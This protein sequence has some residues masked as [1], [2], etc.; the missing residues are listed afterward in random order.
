MT[1]PESALGFYQALFAP[2]PPDHDW[3]R[4]V[5]A[6]LDLE[7]SIKLAAGLP[8]AYR[9]AQQMP[10][11]DLKQMAMD[12]EE[13]AHSDKPFFFA[14]LRLGVVNGREQ[15]DT[16][17]QSLA[18]GAGLLQHGGR[19]MNCLTEHDYAEHLPAAVTRDLFAQGL[20]YR[21]GFLVNS[22]EL[23]SLVHLP[24]S[25]IIDPRRQA[26]A[27]LETLPPE[28]SLSRGTP[29]GQCLYAGMWRSVCIPS[30]MRSKHVHLIGRPGMGKS[31][32]IE[33]MVLHDVG[34]GEGVAVL[35]PHGQMVQRLLGLLP[36]SC[37]DRVIYVDF[38]D[39]EWVPIWNP[40]I[41][42]PGTP[43]GRV[44]E[45]LVGAFK[46]FVTGWGDRLEHMLRHAIFGLMHLPQASL[47]DV[48]NLLRCQSAESERLRPLVIEAMDN[49]LAKA[50]WQEDF[51]KYRSADITPAQHKLGKLVTTAGSV[52]LML[53]QSDSAFN[54][55]DVMETGRIL[56]LDLS[57]LGAEV[58]EILGCFLMSL[59]HL[60]AVSRQRDA[61][62]A[63][64]PFHIYCDEAHKFL[65][66]AMENTIA[67]TRKFGVSLTLAHQYM[68]QFNT[69]KAGALSTVGS[70]V[71]FNVDT[72]DAQ[73]LK[74]DL[75]GLADMD[76]IIT[77]DV[78][79][80]LARIGNQV[81]RL[82][83]HK[84]LDIEPNNARDLFIAQSRER[85]H[86][87]ADQMR[88]A[89]QHRG[90]Q[91]SPRPN[92]EA[93]LTVLMDEGGDQTGRNANH[94]TPQ[95]VRQ[96]DFTYDEF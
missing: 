29:I 4:N 80:A 83:T 42:G 37:A 45:D 19:P 6:L 63:L 75:Q 14:A 56:L 93:V 32:V 31:T 52:A 79:Q 1:V 13:K 59:L 85:Y 78:G 39:R 73:Y 34:R 15:A 28:G 23:T 35:D 10:S 17:M 86:K 20:T 30:D 57:N 2:T 61:E 58:Q 69:R 48:A 53:S 87:P 77:L 70:T 95:D 66:D 41:P 91:R 74:K 25:D 76:D 16:L 44:A 88:Q 84:P 5:R 22:W 11:G 65:T 82:N 26:V 21:P 27:V 81:V 9:Y 96:A 49:P 94:T 92:A 54:L 24:P 55:R 40:L 71:I 90:D 67:E 3:H 38:S 50:F 7:F 72:R 47:L 60:T 68:A 64:K 8:S 89:L 33:H 12:T 62:G 51:A 36:E 46:S 43:I 18:A